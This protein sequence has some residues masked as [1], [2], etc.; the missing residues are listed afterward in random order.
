MTAR[1]KKSSGE[2]SYEIT[3]GALGVALAAG[4]PTT[5]WGGPGEGKNSVVTATAVKLGLHLE[6]VLAS[7]RICGLS[8]L[9]E[10]MKGR[11]RAAAPSTWLAVQQ[12]RLRRGVLQGKSRFGPTGPGKQ[13]ELSVVEP[14]RSTGDLRVLT[15]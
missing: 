5:L 12:P 14:L 6:V 13:A 3:L 10:T 7:V 9:H 8:A 4:I 1:K 2:S 11:S 15:P